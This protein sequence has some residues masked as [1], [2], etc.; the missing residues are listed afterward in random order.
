MYVFISLQHQSVV[1][2]INNIIWLKINM[3]K[4]YIVIGYI[5]LDSTISNVI[6]NLSNATLWLILN[7][8]KKMD[9]I[10]AVCTYLYG[11]ATVA[12]I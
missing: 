9:G 7:W 2:L 3:N 12:I 4:T 11:T 10:Y 8:N 5:G 1:F 6:W